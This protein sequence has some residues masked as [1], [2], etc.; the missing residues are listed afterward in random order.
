MVASH[1]V[2]SEKELA[3]LL[4]ED[5]TLPD[6]VDAPCNYWHETWFLETYLR[7]DQDFLGPVATQRFPY[8]PE[9]VDSVIC[10][11]QGGSAV[12]AFPDDVRALFAEGST[13][14]S[15]FDERVVLDV[16]SELYIEDLITVFR[17]SGATPREIA[18]VYRKTPSRIKY[19]IFIVL[20]KWSDRGPRDLPRMYEKEMFTEYDGG[21]WGW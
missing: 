1:K 19:P 14:D 2:L 9:R 12:K 15:S 10:Q 20:N 3:G 17:H 5:G 16:L 7:P 13:G 18:M 21:A 8:D 4:Q 6:G 11:K